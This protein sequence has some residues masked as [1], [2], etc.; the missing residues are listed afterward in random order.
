VVVEPDAD[1][2]NLA[3]GDLVFWKGHV[4]IVR[5][6]ASLLHANAYHMA[7]AIE[8]LAAAIARIRAAGSAVTSVRRPLQPGTNT[9]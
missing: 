7:V 4:A 3:R 5:D 1:H 2:S 6:S 9:I 8:P